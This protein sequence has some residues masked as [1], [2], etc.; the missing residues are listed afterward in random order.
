MYLRNIDKYPDL[1]DGR[2][3]KMTCWDQ[4][5]VRTAVWPSLDP[6]PKGTVCLLQG[7]AEFAEKYYE[8]IRDLRKRGF[9]VATMDWRG[10]GASER[11][12]DDPLKGHVKR[13]SDYGRDL[14]QFLHEKVL[15]DFPP[16][17]FALSHSMGGLVLLEQLPKLR[18]VFER[19]VLCAPLIEIA[20]EQRRFLGMRLRQSTIRKLTAFLRFLGC[21]SHYMVSVSRSP[22]DRLGFDVNLLTSD[23]PTYDR[24]RQYLIDY[25]ELAIAGPTVRWVHESCKAMARLQSSEMQSSIYTPTL[26][27]GSSQDRIAGTKAAEYF[28]STARAVHAVPIPGARHELMMER[29]ILREEFWAAF[30]AFIPGQNTLTNESIYMPR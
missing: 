14:H 25:P 18:V 13:F 11:L 20:P 12:L 6:H 7:R 22:L 1:A 8:V 15:P 10:Q 29:K 28:A 23:G 30:D 4:R 2:V 26:I 24:N 21:G 17:H 9:A 27:I 16:P 5:V 3:E 19:A